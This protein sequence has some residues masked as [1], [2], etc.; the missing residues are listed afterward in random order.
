MHK[1]LSIQVTKERY[2]GD[3]F[4]T[5]VF[6]ISVLGKIVYEYPIVLDSWSLNDYKQQ[7]MGA[8]ER[9]KANKTSCLVICYT[10]I[11]KRGF[12]GVITIDVFKVLNSKLLFQLRDFSSDMYIKILK[13][14]EYNMQ[15]CYDFIMPFETHNDHGWE[16][17]YWSCDY[18]PQEIDQLIEELKK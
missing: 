4:D 15:S 2:A 8:L 12:P 6:S 3:S 5:F 11:T 10:N 14:K 13:E 7:W 1:N 16:L 18:D 9:L 17:Q